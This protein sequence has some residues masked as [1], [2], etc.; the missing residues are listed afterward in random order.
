VALK[1]IRMMQRRI[2][3]LTIASWRMTVALQLQSLQ[4]SS[5]QLKEALVRALAGVLMGIWSSWRTKDQ[6][7]I[8]PRCRL[9]RYC[10]RST[11]MEEE[12]AAASNLVDIRIMKVTNLDNLLV[13]SID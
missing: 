3:L 7:G 9:R 12:N 2:L 4:R 10:R 13:N 1:V 8:L 11:L 5:L 6:S